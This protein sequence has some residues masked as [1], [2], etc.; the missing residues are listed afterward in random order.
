MIDYLSQP[1]PWYIAGPLIGLIIPALLLLGGKMFGVSENLRHI[2]AAVL[3]QAD[4]FRYDWRK[5]GSWNLTLIAG[6][7][8]GGFLATV[9]IPHPDVIAISEATRADLAAIGVTDVT[10]YVP[11]T[12]ISW[13]GL[14]TIEGFLLVVVG[15]FL[16]G[17]GSK[18]A[19]GCTSG[20]AIMGLA[21]LQLPSLIA[22]IGFFVGGLA[23][24]HLLFPLIF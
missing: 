2:C 1:W 19:G 9:I 3:P 18:Y 6:A 22:V 8:L 12:Y 15:G 11:E 7:V 13:R 10:G 20:H 21:D 23:V 17:F 5:K 4:F 14:F 24:T 16:V